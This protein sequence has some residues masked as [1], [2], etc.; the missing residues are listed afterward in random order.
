MRIRFSRPSPAMIVAATALFVALG[1]T[2]YAAL[3]IPKNAIGAKQIASNAVGSSEIKT[4]AVHSTE[5]KNGTLLKRD[6]KK[7]T[8]PSGGATGAAGGDLAG[9]YPSPTI[10]PDA[11]TGAKIAESTLGRVPDADKLDGV[12]SS[13]FAQGPA[14]I[15]R[16]SLD[17]PPRRSPRRAARR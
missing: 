11:V 6:F 2:G 3:K 14:R 12:D 7:G 8:L 17:C 9:T 1:G 13:G 15:F 16:S 10:R 4:G 5:V